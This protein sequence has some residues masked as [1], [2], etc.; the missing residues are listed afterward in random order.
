MFFFPRI[1]L[2]PSVSVKCRIIDIV[3]IKLGTGFPLIH[4]SLSIEVT[5]INECN[6]LYKVTGTLF[7]VSFPYML[8]AHMNAV[9]VDLK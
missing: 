2:T 5:V 6:L 3:L 9:P 7:N 4:S 1:S 8:A